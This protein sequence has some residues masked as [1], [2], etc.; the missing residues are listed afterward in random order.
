MVEIFT[1]RSGRPSLRVDGVAFHSPFDP[2]REASQFAERSFPEAPPSLVIL[3][4]EGLGYATRAIEERFPGARVVPLFYSAEIFANSFLDPRPSWHPG[5]SRSL[6]EFIISVI[7]ELDLEGLRVIEWPSASRLFP[8]LSRRAHAAVK[9]AA[10]EAN[11]SFMTTAGMGRLW[12]RNSLLNLLSFESV[13]A[14]EPCGAD[15]PILIAASGPSLERHL[16]F[17]REKRDAFDLWAL[18]SS[19]IALRNAGITPDMVV[20]TDPGH[21]SI[22]HL[23]FTSVHC[24]IAMPLSAARGTWR[25]EAGVFLLAQPTFFEMDLLNR[26]AVSAPRVPPNGTVAATALSLAL[27]RSRAKVI[28]AGLDLCFLD[29]LTHARPNGFDRLLA[30]G[31]SRLT[32]HYSLSYHRACSSPHIVQR[33][34]EGVIRIPRSHDTY[35]GWLGSVKSARTFRL[36]VS[37][38]PIP[39]MAVIEENALNALPERKTGGPNFRVNPDF[40]SRG[41]RMDIVAGILNE[42]REVLSQ[43]LQYVK[44]NRDP[45]GIIRPPLL[46]SLAYYTEAGL[47][48]EVRRKARMGDVKSACDSAVELLQNSLSFLGSLGEKILA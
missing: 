7:G 38:V 24:P 47:L 10:L 20:M 6:E 36:G 43:G 41:K 48:M 46:L 37:P 9:R 21:W 4:G 19:L 13:L 35:A 26:A 8:E 45:S 28:L 16:P 1:A 14:G 32:P 27:E 12:L 22:S 30:A 23:D 5:D 44:M 2:Q 34:Q 42:W 40:P 25:F 11:G 31:S 39:S 3:L 33:R 29:I 17:I 15:S 18:P